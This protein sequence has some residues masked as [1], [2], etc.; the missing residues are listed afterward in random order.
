MD[1]QKSN[2]RS[3]SERIAEAYGR[4]IPHERQV[5]PSV[6]GRSDNEMIRDRFDWYLVEREDGECPPFQ[7]PTCAT[8]P[9][10]IDPGTDDVRCF[11]R[12]RPIVS[13]QTTYCANHPDLNHEGVEQPLGPM[14][15]V[16]HGHNDDS[17]IYAQSEYPEPERR[18]ESTVEYN[19]P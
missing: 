14:Y 2:R 13:E 4:L 19:R 15:A 3:L 6:W 16:T 12:K 17:C 8:C 1:N 11:I 7:Y 18:I 5:D 10:A 9:F